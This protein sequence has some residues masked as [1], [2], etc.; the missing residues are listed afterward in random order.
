MK[1]RLSCLTLLA[2]AL[3]LFPQSVLAGEEHVPNSIYQEALAA[4]GRPQADR[5]R[6][7]GR[8]PDQVLAFFDIQPGDHVAELMAGKGYYLDILSRVVGKEGKVYGQNSEFVLKRFA[9][10]ELSKR[11]TNP[12]LANV[13]RIN[14]ELDDPGLPKNLDKVLMVLF[15]HDT[16]WQGVDRKRMNK[17][18]FDALK[19]GGYFCVID[20]HAAPGSGDRDVS[21]LHRVDVALVKKE[22]LT[23]G[24]VLD[25][26][27]DILRN[28]EDTRDYNVFRDVKTNRDQ[29]DR[30][31]LRFRKPSK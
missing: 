31:V 9:E 10:K 21:S 6:D 3:T 27:S 2:C 23:A 11:L 22:L 13:V 5:V 26:E 16:Y 29:T 7:K 19:P 4:E 14:R 25:G 24:F 15:Y 12:E 30:F 8:K 18:V 17:A 1:F 28:P 20:H